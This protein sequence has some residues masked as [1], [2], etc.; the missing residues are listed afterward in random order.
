[1]DV[2][3]DGDACW[4]AERGAGQGEE[5]VETGLGHFDDVGVASVVAGP[6]E[7]GFEAFRVE[8]SHS[9]GFVAPS[10]FVVGDSDLAVN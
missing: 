2:A 4:A 10:Q 1:M 7:H 6:G 5:V 8:F 3:D 9:S